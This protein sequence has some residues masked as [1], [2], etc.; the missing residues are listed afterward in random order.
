VIYP[1]LADHQKVQSTLKPVLPQGCGHL[2]ETIVSNIDD[3]RSQ[4]I[5]GAVKDKARELINGPDLEAK[6][7]TER[8]NGIIQEQAGKA[9]WKAGKA[10]KKAAKVISGKR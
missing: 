5:E 1:G 8:L 9:R 6:S 3:G 7:E 10:M 4:S 2:K